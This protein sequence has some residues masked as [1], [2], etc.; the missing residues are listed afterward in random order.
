MR[1]VSCSL[2]ATYIRNTLLGALRESAKIDT[3]K[4]VSNF[5]YDN[6]SISRLASYVSALALGDEGTVY[7]GST[8][9]ARIDAMRAMVA[10][11][12]SDFPSRPASR[13][14]RPS[15]DVVVVTGTTGSL[16]CHL[17][18]K[19]ASDYSVSRVYGFNRP[20]RNQVPLRERQGSALKD[21]GL[22]ASILDS[23]KIVLLEGDITKDNWGLSQE[24][25]DELHESVTHIIHNAWRVD[26]VIN[27]ESFDNSVQSV[28]RLVDFALT[29][30]LSEAPRIVFTGS[31]GVFQNS[32]CDGVFLEAPI[33]P[34]LAVGTGY[35]ESKWVSEQMLYKAAAETGLDPLIVRVGQ[36]CGGLDGAWNTHEWF[37]TLVQSAPK[38]GCFPDDTKG[39]NWIPLEIAAGAVVD[40]RE[41]S[42]PTH[43][44]HLVHPRPVSWHS[45]ATVVSAELNVPLVPFVDWLAKLEQTAQSLSQSAYERGSQ[46]DPGTEMV[47]SLRALQLLPFFKVVGEKLVS[48]RMA[49]GLPDLSVE[50]AVKGSPTL[51]DPDIRQLGSE[52][53]K[54]WL[55]Y[56]RKVGLFL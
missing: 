3:R 9:S 38:L 40:F 14:T 26:F 12:T 5:I 19:L 33:E 21:R 47:R 6:P 43:T 35:A 31:I 27:L 28:R 49:M 1:H 42:N 22:D 25:Y 48:A 23:E 37:P 15:K 32:P 16:G 20:A 54:R 53:V 39:V 2:Q 55:A 11:Y 17:L 46:A 4:V 50:Q 45:L 41:A 52:D 51:A 34:D 8:V 24:T 36:I 7:S 29:S 30:A 44:V 56:W 18:A 13:K 10:K